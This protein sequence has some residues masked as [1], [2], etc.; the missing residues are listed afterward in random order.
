M[1]VSNAVTPD[2]YAVNRQHKSSIF[3]MLFGGEK[4]LL[5]LYNAINGTSY[6]DPSL[7]RV[8]TLENAI[9]LGLKNDISF[10]IDV[11]LHQYEHQSTWNPNMPLR[12]LFYV[13]DL[14]SEMTA[15][16]NLYGSAKVN[17]PA[18]RFF[19]FYNGGARCPDRVVLKLSDLYWKEET[20]PSLDLEVTVLNINK[21]H[22]ETL[23]KS[24]RALRE[25]AEYT[26]RVRKNAASL[27]LH[28]AVE[29]A[30]TSCI[31]DGILEDFLLKNRAEVM[32]VSIYEYNAE[33]HLRMEREA[34]L[35]EGREEL[36]RRLIKNWTE[37]GKTPSQIAGDLR[38]SEETVRKLIDKVSCRQT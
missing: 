13:S 18:P 5:E 31:R 37:D 21:G 29:S 1:P 9:Y 32:K 11:R 28:E 24:C 17:I 12:N 8:N 30:V 10:L 2:K 27:P 23:M 3:A 7:L 4:E 34:A 36:L 20:H 33:E 14:Y 38:E 22:N 35:E 26:A 19:V 25:Y 16:K 15:K 6:T